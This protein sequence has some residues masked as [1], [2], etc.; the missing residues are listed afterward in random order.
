MK[1][2]K[3]KFLQGYTI[4]DEVEKVLDST[5][6]DF[7][8]INSFKES[9]F[10]NLTGII[11]TD[12]KELIQAFRYEQDKKVTFLPE[13]NPITIYFDLAHRF[14]T[15]IEN[16][17]EDIHEYIKTPNFDVYVFLNKFNNY[18]ATISGCV[19]FLFISIEAFINNLIPDDFTYT[20]KEGKVYDIM[21]IQ[22]FISFDDKLKKI[23]PSIKEKSFHEKYGHKYEV[24]INLKKFRDEITHTK[25]YKIDSPNFYFQ[26]FNQSLKF[27]FKSSIY[28]S[29]DL[30]NF[31]EK[32]LIEDCGC[33]KEH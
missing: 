25:A 31:Y 29:R 10:E 28:A 22:K 15:T 6:P 21:G 9:N 4:N 19:T 13:P 27:D 18:Y 16:K 11:Q 17:R 7:D 26:L 20:D 12:N 3:K 5:R 2:I 1:H 8:A 24:I 30:I 23:I 32:D 14:Y 33:G